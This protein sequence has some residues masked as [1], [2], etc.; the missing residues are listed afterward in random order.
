MDDS[1]R[2]SSTICGWLEAGGHRLALAQVGPDFCVVRQ[3][4]ATPPSEAE[5][6]IEIDGHERRKR[7]F[8]SV[9]ISDSSTLVKFADGRN[10]SIGMQLDR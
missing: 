2:Y 5:L 1:N 8:L 7:V 3:S 4:V 9:G 6:V 10:F